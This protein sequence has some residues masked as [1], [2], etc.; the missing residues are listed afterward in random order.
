MTNT[1]H[2]PTNVLERRT[3]RP[4]AGYTTIVAGA[5]LVALGLLCLAYLRASHGG[6]IPGALLGGLASVFIA[7]GGSLVIHGKKVIAADAFT[8][9]QK[10]KRKP[11]LYLRSFGDDGTG[12]SHRSEVVFT[13]FEERIAKTL[14]KLGPVVA[15]GRPNE[16]LP[17]L[18]A[19]RLYVSD[20]EW[21]QAVHELMGRAQLVVLRAGESEGLIWEFR[22]TV[23]RLKPEQILIF[24]PFAFDREELTLGAATGSA[25][26]RVIRRKRKVEKSSRQDQ[27]SIFRKHVESFFPKGLPKQIGDAFLFSFHS[28]WTPVVFS[29]DCTP[30]LL[31]LGTAKDNRVLHQLVKSFATLRPRSS[32]RQAGDALL[33]IAIGFIL[34]IIMGWLALYFWG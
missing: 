2:S 4:V 12:I 8:L 21:Q 3:R 26:N 20:D 7:V 15:I 28:D 5:C 18:G 9:L 19:A 24:L 33:R 17:E 16:A 1:P 32:L 6:A 25:W 10:D 13:S 29:P 11:V 23:E 14:S 22:T 31:T 30:D 34:F 27:Y